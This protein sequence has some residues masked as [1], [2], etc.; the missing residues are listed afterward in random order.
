MKVQITGKD[1]WYKIKNVDD[2]IGGMSQQET[3][4]FFFFFLFNTLSMGASPDKF[5]D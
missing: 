3:F 4:F 1:V 2:Q 5:T